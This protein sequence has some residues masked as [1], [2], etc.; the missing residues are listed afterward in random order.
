MNPTLGNDEA[1]ARARLAIRNDGDFNIP[2]GLGVAGAILEAGQVE[3][4]TKDE[5]HGLAGHPHMPFEGFPGVPLGFPDLVLFLAVQPEQ[6]FFLGALGFL[7]AAVNRLERFVG[8]E[9]VGHIVRE[10][11]EE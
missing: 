7:A 3:R 1:P 4:V 8:L 9:I 5:G 6:E 10:V 2:L 11:R